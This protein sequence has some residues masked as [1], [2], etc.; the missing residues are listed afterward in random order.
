MINKIKNLPKFW[1]I[2]LL[3]V[4]I[5]AVVSIT[6][7]I[8][9]WGYLIGYEKTRST[10]PMETLVEEINM[11]QYDMMLSYTNAKNY[12][13]AIQQDFKEKLAEI[14]AG[15]EVY[16]EKAFSKDKD[17]HPAFSLKIGD[18][19]LATVT[20]EKT[21][22]KVAFGMT[23]YQIMSITDLP[24]MSESVTI[25]APKGYTIFL[26]GDVISDRDT[27]LVEENIPVKGISGIPEKYFQ[28]PTM[29]KYKITDLVDQPVVT[30]KTETGEPANVITSEDGKECTVSF[31][32]TQNAEVYYK[33]ALTLA[34]LYSQYVT[35]WVSEGK[36]LAKVLVDSPIREGLASVQTS[37]YTD[38]Q[39]DYFTDEVAE[40]LQIYSDNCF[41]CDISYTQWVESI[42]NN[43]DFKKA[44]PSA[45]TF[46]FVKVNN[47]WYIADMEIRAAK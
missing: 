40:N 44:L 7:W 3:V 24:I 35:A 2:Y 17:N 23:G 18:I 47:S 39:K 5:L 25:T 34:K 42:R 20:M 37:F 30:A 38:H 14:V 22:D 31:G 28:K 32:S 33:E 1:Q 4:G 9:L 16:Y 45:F 36:I 6:V 21:S 8:V 41:S 10:V 27:F 12:D 19:K 46:Y 11:G 13:E 43:P 29:V 26:N 15:Q